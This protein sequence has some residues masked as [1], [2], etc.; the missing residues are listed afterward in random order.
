AGDRPEVRHASSAGSGDSSPPFHFHSALHCDR[1]DLCRGARREPAVSGLLHC[2]VLRL[3]HLDNC[4]LWRHYANHRPR[5]PGSGCIHLGRSRDH[6]LSA[7]Q[8]GRGLHGYCELR[9]AGHPLPEHPGI[10]GEFGPPVPFVQR[11]PASE[12]C[13]L[14]LALWCCDACRL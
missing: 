10:S 12:G 14:L 5:S 13:S 7:E 6:P 2:L 9:S 4:G 3:D 11:D 1:G 8:A